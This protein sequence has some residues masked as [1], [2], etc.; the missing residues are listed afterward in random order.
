MQLLVL[1]ALF[2]LVRNTNK[3]IAGQGN[4]KREFSFNAILCVISTAFQYE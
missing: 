1:E 3:D 2:I 4:Q